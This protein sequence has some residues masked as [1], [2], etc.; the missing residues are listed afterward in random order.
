MG[1]IGSLLFVAAS[2]AA[3][4]PH[5]AATLVT[6]VE[7]GVFTTELTKF[8]RFVRENRLVYRELDWSTDYCS[9]PFVGNAGRSFNFRL[10]CQRHDFGYRNL[11][12]IG[13]F[14]EENR[15][16]VDDRF[17][18]DMR[19]T[20]APREVTQRYKCYLWADTFYVAVRIFA[21]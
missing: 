4:S 2:V 21:D 13:A 20:C 12:I 8:P 5:S 7:R 15:K 9:A 10:P 6:V 1:L 17:L 14:T 18:A 3:P 11:K 16:R 19:T